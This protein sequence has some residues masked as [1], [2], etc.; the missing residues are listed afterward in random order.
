MGETDV[1]GEIEAQ[2][3][4]EGTDMPLCNVPVDV[5]MEVIEDRT[6]LSPTDLPTIFEDCEENDDGR[7]ASLLTIETIEEAPSTADDEEPLHEH[8]P[9][10]SLPLDYEYWTESGLSR[11]TQ[12]QRTST[13]C[14]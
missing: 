8:P 11:F 6:H 12:D 14:L 13:E 10:K 1:G 2:E 4:E 5:E 9:P 7:S 3:V